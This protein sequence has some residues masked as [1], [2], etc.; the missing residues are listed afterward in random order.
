MLMAEAVSM[1][2]PWAR[3]MLDL[4]APGLLALPSRVGTQ[5]AAR[6]LRWAFRQGYRS[7]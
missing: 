3:S 4:E 1:L 5:A 7:S 2:P 6:T